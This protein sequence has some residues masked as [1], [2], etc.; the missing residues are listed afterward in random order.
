M[1][2]ITNKK[3]RVL[4]VIPSRYGSTRLPGKPLVLIEGTPMIQWVYNRV[5]SVSLI[6]EV[7]VATDDRR[8]F[9]VVKKFGGEVMMTSKKHQSGTDRVAEVV[10][11]ME[12]I[13]KDY[14]FILNVQGDEPLISPETLKKII[15]E[16]KK[17]VCVNV[18][19]PVC[20]IKNYEE[21]ISP[22]TAK[23]V[24]D[25]EG[26]ALF[27]SRH[28]IPFIREFSN[29]NSPQT[30]NFFNIKFKKEKLYRHIGIYGYRK[31]FLLKYVKMPQ[32]K[33]EK[34]EKLE[35]LRIL[36][37]GYKIKVVEVKDTSVP[38]DTLADLEK[39]REIV[40]IKSKR[41]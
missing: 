30:E 6:D 18:I 20:R 14:D 4:A 8:I 2:K 37:N 24:F 10:I 5:K 29:Y 28:A 25:K 12:Q 41:K 1:Q 16:F 15:L 31:D 3:I 38:V 32:S 35:Q 9:D 39:V 11:K 17:D 7:I 27:F 40:K 36:E 22:H 26:F 33:L 34:L 19:T 21:Y 23:V 13:S